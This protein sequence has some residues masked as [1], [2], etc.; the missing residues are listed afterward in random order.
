MPTTWRTPLALPALA[1]A[2]AWLTVAGHNSVLPPWVR[3]RFPRVSD[4]LHRLRDVPCGETDCRYCR[5]THD[6]AA[7]LQ[8]YFGFPAFRSP[9]VHGETGGSLQEA[10]VR[11]GMADQPL[12]AIL[13]TGGGKSICYQIPA[14]VR[15]FRRG[16]LTI[17]ITPL[18][19]LM[20]DQV[21][22]LIAK[23]GLPCAA[24]LS[25]LLTPPERGRRPRTS[26]P[27]RCGPAL[28]GPRTAPESVLPES[29]QPAGNRLLGL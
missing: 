14:L 23:T 24:A 8:R 13:P 26:A 19:A 3:H 27:R 6:P 5:E 4:W 28:C 10:I 25:G 15:H 29:H 12:L 21:D 2:V 20:K 11:H 22:N 16:Q 1:Y 7:Q 9:P 17:V 18:Q